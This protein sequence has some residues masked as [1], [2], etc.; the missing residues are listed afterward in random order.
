MSEKTPTTPKCR[1]VVWKVF[2]KPAERNR[3]RL[4]CPLCPGT[5]IVYGGTT[6]GLKTHLETHHKDEMLKIEKAEVT[7]YNELTKFHDLQQTSNAVA[8]KPD[9]SQIYLARSFATGG[10][11]FSFSKNPEFVRFLTSKPENFVIP[12]PK[13]IKSLIQV[14]AIDYLEKLTHEFKKVKKY[15]LMTDGYSKVQRGFHFYSVH[16]GFVD[17]NFTRNVKFVALR[18]VE[19]GDAVSVSKAINGVLED[20]GLKLSDCTNITSDAGSPLVLLADL[21]QI[22]RFH[23]FQVKA[24][25]STGFRIH[26]ACHLL[27]LIICEFSQVK[28]VANYYKVAQKLAAHLGRCKEDKNKLKMLAEALKIKSPLPLPLPTTRWGGM[29]IL[30][31]NYIDNYEA[32]K[33]V[34]ILKKYLIKEANMNKMKELVVLLKPIHEGI[35]KLEKD[36]SYVSEI[37]PTMVWIRHKISQITSGF[38]TILLKAVDKRLAQC[39]RNK[40]ILCT[41]LV[42]HRFAYVDKWVEPMKWCDV[43]ERIGLYETKTASFIDAKTDVSVVDESFENYVFKHSSSNNDNNGSMESE[44]VRYRAFLSTNRPSDECPLS[45][46]KSQKNN[47]QK[48][49]LIA[50]ELLCS[51]ASSSVSER[52]FSKCSDFVRQTKRNRA[53]TETLNDLLTVTELCKLKRTQEIVA[54]DTDESD[55]SDDDDEWTKISIEETAAEE[56]RTTSNS[57]DSEDS[58]SI[59]DNDDDLVET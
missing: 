14:E 31:R 46:W 43:E 22:D 6:S 54:S 48:L 18:N 39:I 52:C 37:I 44:I 17:K 13:Q 28:G 30:L 10:I 53:T 24:Y 12:S 59:I 35:L 51:P 42:D 3:P 45:F 25:S 49:S 9:Q 56:M 55:L 26:C 57:E 15:C 7:P 29:H 58:F 16:V 34:A 23:F 40:R 1:S 11:P 36:S 2:K 32:I 33:N 19:K 4:P 5:S 21:H 38:S 20:V 27:N 41:M 8:V 47:F 50:S